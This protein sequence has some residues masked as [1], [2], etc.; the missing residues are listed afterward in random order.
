M[1]RKGYF[2]L[3]IRYGALYFGAI[4]TL[5][6]VMLQAVRTESNVVDTTLR[7]S[8]IF[9]LMGFLLGSGLWLLLFLY[10]KRRS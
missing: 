10:R 1:Q 7:A 2:D 3:A 6:F 8:V 9:P 4:A 5:I